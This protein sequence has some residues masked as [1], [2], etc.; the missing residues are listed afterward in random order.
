MDDSFWVAIPFWYVTSHAGQ[1]NLLSEMGNEY[2]PM[3]DDTVWLRSNGRMALYLS[4]QLDEM[5]MALLLS[6]GEH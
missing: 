4:A 3:C 1:L 5:L 2:Q 6:G